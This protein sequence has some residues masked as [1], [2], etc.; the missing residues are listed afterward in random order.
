MPESARRRPERR[1]LVAWPRG[2]T[3]V[4]AGAPGGRYFDVGASD[5]AMALLAPAATFTPHLALELDGVLD[6][7]R[8]RAAAVLLTA[9]HPILGAAVERVGGTLRWVPGAGAPAGVDVAEHPGAASAVPLD[10]HAGPVWRV[11]AVTGADP[12][13]LVIG[14]HHALGDGRA[15]VVLLEDLHR[16]YVALATE[17]A[18]VVDVDWSPRSIA[19]GLDARRVPATTRVRLAWEAG[20]RWR[21]CAVSTHRDPP[22]GSGAEA[23]PVAAS[24]RLPALG[25]VASAGGWRP[26]HVLLALA[27]RAWDDV[28]GHPAGPSVSSWLV[29]IDTRRQLALTRGIGNLSGFEPV[30]LVDLD[31]EDPVRDVEQAA[32]VFEPLTTLGAGMLAEL[33]A[34]PPAMAARLLDR[35]LV[36]EVSRRGATTRLTRCYSNVGSLSPVLTD[37]DGV[38]AVGARWLPT[39]A[40]PPPFV[41]VLGV[42]FRDVTTVTLA[43]ST[44]T[45]PEPLAVEYAARLVSSLDEVS[46]A[47]R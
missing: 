10:P 32:A 16:L 15:L 28:F 2:A 42:G 20:E 31:G 36:D 9:R 38:Q 23:T 34:A 1:P 44:H 25:R 18:P 27:A 30:T 19:A 46:A 14:A 45:I 21:R 5:R 7:E 39:A 4:I 24:V 26:N 41:G 40:P 8:L 29:T 13:L 12:P 37:W 33:L 6:T 47:A 3:R 11:V 17:R 22:S 43:A 35:G